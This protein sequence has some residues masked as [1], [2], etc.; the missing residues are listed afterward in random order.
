MK[1]LKMF[2]APS[3]LR[4]LECRNISFEEAVRRRQV[5]MGKKLFVHEDY[6]K[7]VIFTCA[8]LLEVGTC[9]VQSAI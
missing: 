4:M 9:L 5:Y 6:S 8:W 3:V 7:M 2:T 1:H